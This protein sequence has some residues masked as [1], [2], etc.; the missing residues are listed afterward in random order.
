MSDAGFMT[1]LKDLLT[2]HRDVLTTV[3]TNWDTSSI[4]VKV[5]L[6]DGMARRFEYIRIH[7]EAIQAH[8]VIA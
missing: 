2:T 4:A 6:I 8:G 7:L 1:N 3:L 5:A